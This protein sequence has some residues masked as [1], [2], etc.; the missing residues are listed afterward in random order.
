MRRI[1]HLRT[2]FVK[3]VASWVIEGEEEAENKK[4]F[5][6]IHGDRGS[7]HSLTIKIQMRASGIR[8]M[9]PMLFREQ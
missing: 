9:L 7:S 2:V 3:R 5:A 6:I 8:W 1:V 4:D